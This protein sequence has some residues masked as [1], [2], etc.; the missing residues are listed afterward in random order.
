MPPPYWVQSTFSPYAQVQL[1]FCPLCCRKCNS[2]F[3]VCVRKH[4]RSISIPALRRGELA[5]SFIAVSEVQWQHRVQQEN[6]G[7]GTLV[8]RHSH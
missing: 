4:Q 7:S 1:V 3:R 5:I 8:H 6:A 2:A